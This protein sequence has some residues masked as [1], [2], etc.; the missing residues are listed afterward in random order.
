ML[1]RQKGPGPFVAVP[2]GR[3]GLRRQPGLCC[4]VNGIHQLA[5]G[6]NGSEE[7]GRSLRGK[8]RHRHADE[9]GIRS[10]RQIIR[11]RGK[12]DLMGIPGRISPFSF[13][14]DGTTQEIGEVARAQ[15]LPDGLLAHLGGERVDHCDKPGARQGSRGA[16]GYSQGRQELTARADPLFVGWLAPVPVSPIFKFGSAQYGMDQAVARHLLGVPDPAVRILL[17][18]EMDAPGQTGPALKGRIPLRGER[19][20]SSQVAEHAAAAVPGAAAVRDHAAAVEKSETVVVSEEGQ[21]ATG[22]ASQPTCQRQGVA[23]LIAV[24]AVEKGDALN[25]V[26]NF[27]VLVEETEDETAAAAVAGEHDA[28]IV[29]PENLPQ[30]VDQVDNLHPVIGG[31][32][33]I[34]RRPAALPGLQ[35]H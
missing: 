13:E 25:I 32:R 18:E 29:D 24:V 34:P 27:I 20:V 3:N 7:V 30:A 28:W 17:Q 4:S 6:Q 26:G 11:Q 14:E 5:G 35:Q 22:V 33:R 31:M 12:H 15:L 19:I 16:P 21:H 23:A 1:V 9:I 8:G 10:D 2:I